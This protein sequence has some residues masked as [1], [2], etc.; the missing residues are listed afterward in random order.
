MSRDEGF[1][2][3]DISVDIVNDPKVRRLFRE[4]SD[5]AAPAFVAYVA[6]LGESWRAGRRVSIEDSWPAA[7]PFVSDVVDAL[8]HV[9]L[10][11]ARGF[12]SARAWRG[13]FVPANA[14]REA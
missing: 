13:W 11:G 8:K 14:R 12:I 6:M 7:L 1:A 3:M 10:I 4:R 5:E 2:V 9:K